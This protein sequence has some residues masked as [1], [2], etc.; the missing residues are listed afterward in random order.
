MGIEVD[1]IGVVG[2]EC[3]RKVLLG[4]RRQAGQRRVCRGLLES[5]EMA[6]RQSLVE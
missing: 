1:D 2:I 4:V 3:T 6:L 5:L